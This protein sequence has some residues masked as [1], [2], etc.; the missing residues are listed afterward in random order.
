ML[1]VEHPRGLLPVSI[2]FYACRR[3]TNLRRQDR[4]LFTWLQFFSDGHV[5]MYVVIHMMD[6]ISAIA[7]YFQATVSRNLRPV[8]QNEVLHPWKSST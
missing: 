6:F 3:E 2:R 7:T 1:G 5:I 8:L 4:M